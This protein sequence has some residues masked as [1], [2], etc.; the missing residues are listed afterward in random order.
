MTREPTALESFAAY[1]RTVLRLVDEIDWLNAEERE[2]IG[3]IVKACWQAAREACSDLPDSNK[4]L[5]RM[6]VFAQ[7]LFNSKDYEA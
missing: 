7:E 4:K 5:I 3:H 1:E 2:A 6:A